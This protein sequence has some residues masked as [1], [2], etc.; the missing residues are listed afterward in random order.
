MLPAPFKWK[1]APT[2]T[3]PDA[4]RIL[5]G[6]AEAH[7]TSFPCEQTEKWCRRRIITLHH[8]VKA[9]FLALWAAWEKT[10]VLELLVA[11][12]LS[13]AKFF[14]FNGGWVARYKRGAPE[15]QNAR[16]LSNHSTGHAFDIMAGRYPLGRVVPPTDPIH[17]LVPIAAQHNWNWGGNFK[18]PD[19]MHW[20]HVKSLF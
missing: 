5:G 9:D 3:D 7:I 14:T 8:D 20:Q 12:Q 18:R 15:D 13:P 17:Q 19:G 16:H 6:W 11:D 1:H 4:I 2:A 10:G